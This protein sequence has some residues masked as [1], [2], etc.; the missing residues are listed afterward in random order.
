M[1]TAF[2]RRLFWALAMLLW[3]NLA[4]AETSNCSP[5]QESI[6]FPGADGTILRGD[7]LSPCGSEASQQ[8]PLV[9][10]INPFGQSFMT[11]RMQALAFTREGFRTLRYNARGWHSSDGSIT[12]D[13]DL[14]AKDAQKALDWVTQHYATGRIGVAGISEGGGVSLLLASMDT[15]LSAIGVLSGWTDMLHNSLGATPRMT[16]GVILAGIVFAAGNP[17]DLI[18]D[19]AKQARSNPPFDPHAMMRAISPWYRLNSI[20]ASKPAIFMSHAMDDTLFPSNQIVDFYHHLH[21]DKYL[22]INRGFHAGPEILSLPNPNAQPWQSLRQW[23]RDY[24]IEEKSSNL[25]GS[26]QIAY[27]NRN[28]ALILNNREWRQPNNETHYLV[29]SETGYEL[30]EVAQASVEGDGLKVIQRARDQSGIHS[31]TPLISAFFNMRQLKTVKVPVSKI[32]RPYA[33]A[34]VGPVRDTTTTIFG[35]PKLT[36]HINSQAKRGMVVAHLVDLE[37]GKEDGNLITHAVYT[38]SNADRQPTG[39]I[40]LQFEFYASA[41]RLEAGHRLALILNS[42]DIEYLPP[43]LLSY[44]YSILP[45]PGA[46]VLSFASRPIDAPQAFIGDAITTDDE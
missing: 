1:H 46:Q 41:W 31:G 28:E 12:L 20:N 8:L 38:W 23:F 16:W 15:R 4:Q 25:N 19:I 39:E 5:Q 37:D 18:K 42:S 10:L 2:G 13:Y 27:K 32:R 43:T 45:N 14:Q 29:Q 35:S 44:N 24:L 6:S 34:F 30:S 40:K 26:I 33:V 7:L 17:I 22:Q 36:M 11:Y 21:G 9:M 3:V